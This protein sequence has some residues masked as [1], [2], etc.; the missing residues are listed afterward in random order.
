MSSTEPTRMVVVDDTNPSIVYSGTW[1]H[2][3]G[4]TGIA[5][6]SDEKILGP[7]F[8]GTATFAEGDLSL[9]FAFTGTGINLNGG[10]NFVPTGTFAQ[11]FIDGVATDN[12]TDLMIGSG[13]VGTND[14]P[15]C[16]DPIL[17]DGTHVLTFNISG[18]GTYTPAPG[19][20]GAKN[21]VWIDEVVYTPSTS[22]SIDTVPSV[23]I[24]AADSQIQYS[25]G[26]GTAANDD[27][28]ATSQNGAFVTFEFQGTS[29]D[30]YGTLLN[31]ALL[32][33]S[34]ATYSIDDQTPIPFSIVDFHLGD[35]PNGVPL[36]RSGTLPAGKHTLKVVNQGN[37]TVT[38]LALRYLIVVPSADSTVNTVTTTSSTATTTTTTASS[39]PTTNT[40][41]GTTTPPATTSDS[42]QTQLL[43]NLPLGDTK[44]HLSAGVIG[45]IVAA[46]VILLA[47]LF[48]L[49]LFLRRRRQRKTY[50]LP[51]SP[52]LDTELKYPDISAV[53]RPEIPTPLPLPG[54]LP[55]GEV[56]QYSTEKPSST[57]PPI[58]PFNSGSSRK[59]RLNSDTSPRQHTIEL[60]QP[61]SQPLPSTKTS[62]RSPRHLSDLIINH[63]DSGLR[64]PQPEEEIRRVVESPPRY[65]P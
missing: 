51:H 6:A 8:N 21:R 7:P 48:I 16:A 18:L 12:S 11:C 46:V 63:D 9:S 35:T 24:F 39:P 42:T 38:P 41:T 10:I 28:Q 49:F 61:S 56:E 25:A 13:V 37:T 23:M 26:W 14:N 45:G 5:S 55:R 65:M 17:S 29:I 20:N 34:S 22:V 1:G 58:Q 64:L 57:S 27:A 3:Q 43:P 59:R 19:A 50:A 30:Y 54:P 32:N 2:D 33:A 36:F 15:L 53:P 62:E 31:N 40:S 52:A 47:S 4:V 60:S 44:K